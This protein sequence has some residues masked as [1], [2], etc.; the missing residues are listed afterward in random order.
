M[1]RGSP[2]HHHNANRRSF[3]SQLPALPPV[4]SPA[5]VPPD[6]EDDS[7]YSTINDISLL[8]KPYLSYSKEALLKESESEDEVYHSLEAV[9]LDDL[10][11]DE[12]Y[13]NASQCR[14]NTP[15]VARKDLIRPE[16]DNPECIYSE[17]RKPDSSPLLRPRA[18]RQPP[19]SS[20][21]QPGSSAQP[22]AGDDMKEMEE[23][24]SSSAHAP[25]TE[26]PSSFKQR[27]A[28]IISKDLARFQPPLP[29]AL[30]NA[31]FPQEQYEPQ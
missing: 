27:L 4:H 17:A 21:I 13:Y 9:T 2:S 30:C 8:S 6:A 10:M 11:E 22:Q 14:S 5:G 20:C 24:N 15:P 31:T 29:P 7:T 23:A 28:E 19:A 18:Q 26:T 25:P 12:K 3:I 1:D 16:I